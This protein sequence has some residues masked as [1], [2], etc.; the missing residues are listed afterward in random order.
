LKDRF[1]KK[2]HLLKKK[3]VVDFFPKK[4]QSGVILGERRT[5]KDMSSSLVSRGKL[6]VLKSGTLK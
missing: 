2:C 5:K 4:N 1:S 6:L 3:G